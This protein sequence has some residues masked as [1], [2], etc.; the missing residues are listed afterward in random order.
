MG[1][2]ILSHTG[3]VKDDREG[4]ILMSYGPND[5]KIGYGGFK[6]QIGK[7]AL[8]DYKKFAIAIRKSTSNYPISTNLSKSTNVIVNKHI[9]SGLRMASKVLPYQGIT[10][11]CVNMSSVGLW[12]NGIPN[13]GI[14][15]YFLHY[16][17]VSY[18]SG[19]RPDILSYYLLY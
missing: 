18:N 8:G 9:F 1:Q 11:N 13:I 6:D 4:D 2:K 19:F 14:H 10:I 16:S 7:K 12:L 17:I 15:P 3:I 5:E